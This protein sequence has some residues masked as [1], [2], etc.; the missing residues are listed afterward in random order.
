M[1]I[2]VITNDP[3]KPEKVE[4]CP[5]YEVDLGLELVEVTEI[6]RDEF[7]VHLFPCAP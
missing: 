2:E 6:L 3:P 5:E 4:P 1:E 7:P